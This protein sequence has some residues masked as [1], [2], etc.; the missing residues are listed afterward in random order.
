MVSPFKRT[1]GIGS[2]FLALGLAATAHAEPDVQAVPVDFMGSCTQGLIVWKRVEAK[3]PRCGYQ[4]IPQVKIFDGAGKLRFIGSA[5]D[6]MQ[7]AKSGQPAT[8]IPK[9]VVV[10]D[11]A[12]EARL[13]H[14]AAPSAGHGWVTYYGWGDCPPCRAQL[15][16]FRAEVLPKLDAGTGV[17]VF[18]PK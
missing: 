15:V 13:T 4:Q 2:M 1:V 8:P 18:D 10:R 9:D 14:V 6:A 12:T 17:T 7:W 5:L 3:G 11:V 16:T